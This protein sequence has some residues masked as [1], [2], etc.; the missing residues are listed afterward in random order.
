MN[1][2]AFLSALHESPDDEV[3]WAALADWLDE[4]DQPQRAE[5]VRL[6]R[7]LRAL[8]VMKRT[9]QRAEMEDRVAELLRGGVRPAVAEI[10]NSIGMRFALIPPGRFR[11]GSLTT[12][13]ARH[14][15]ERAHEV[16]LTRPYYL[17]VFPVTQGEY[18]AVTGSNP[19]AYSRRGSRSGQTSRLSEARIASLPVESVSWVDAQ[20]FLRK[21]NA[22]PAEKKAGRVHRLPTE[23]EWEY[24]CRGGSASSTPFS[25]GPALSSDLA[26]FDGNYP[27]SGAAKGPFL[28]RTSKVG[29]Y[30]PNAFGLYDVHGN[31]FE[32]CQDWHGP[33]PSGTVTD[34]TGP[35]E[36]DM[37]IDRGGAWYFTADICRAGYRDC[38]A[39]SGRYSF[40]GFRVAVSHPASK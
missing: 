23:A 30:P 38:T 7:R 15:D 12:E 6:V 26:N 33:Y 27:S 34:P 39:E 28:N 25:F 13:R 40:L 24:A 19:S 31:V 37:R 17:G 10:T 5:L 29:A 22:L 35:A 1:E 36:G 2:A 14:H 21:L 4:D 3:T 32:W 9:T 8:P 20:A 16:I 11:M 18:A